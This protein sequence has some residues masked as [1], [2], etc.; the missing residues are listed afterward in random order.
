[1]LFRVCPYCGANLDPAEKCDCC[2]S[3]EEQQQAEKRRQ[4]IEALR[5]SLAKHQE[6]QARLVSKERYLRLGKVRAE[7][8]RTITTTEKTA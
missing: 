8:L 2:P 1:M 7:L 3:V 6:Q 5:I 4:Q